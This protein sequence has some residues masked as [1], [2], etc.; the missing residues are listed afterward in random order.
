V[1]F[2]DEITERFDIVDVLAVCF[3]MAVLLFCRRAAIRAARELFLFAS[4]CTASS[5]AVSRASRNS[6][7]KS[8]Q[9]I[10]ASRRVGNAPTCISGKRSAMGACRFCSRIR[11]LKNLTAFR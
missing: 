10:G 7:E 9:S 5:S 1:F 2:R 3:G 8:D 4:A 6:C 11:R